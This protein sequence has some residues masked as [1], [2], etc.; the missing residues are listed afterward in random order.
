LHNFEI[1]PE[2][3]KLIPRQVCV[4]HMVLPL[5]KAGKSLVVAFA[6]PSNIYVK[7]DLALLTR[8]KIEAVVASETSINLA[9]DKYYS[10][11]STR[12]DNI[13]SEMEE[14]GEATQIVASNVEVIDSEMSS[15]E[16]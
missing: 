11:G 9:I 15:D 5:S 2:A 14:S 13:V 1:D 4:K 16:F 6:D 3:I 12:I 10:V 8:C 7:D